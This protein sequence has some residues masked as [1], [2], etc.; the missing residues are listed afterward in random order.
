MRAG[1][2]FDFFFFFRFA[3]EKKA[4][5]RLMLPGNV[6]FSPCDERRRLPL[7]PLSYSTS[8]IN[9]KSPHSMHSLF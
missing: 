4:A 7:S 8:K 3:R 1:S 5:E 9:V 6:S 2:P